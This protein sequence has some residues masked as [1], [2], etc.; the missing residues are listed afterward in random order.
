[1]ITFY[2]NG[3]IHTMDNSKPLA[4]ALIVENG[5]F[6]YVGREEEDRKSVV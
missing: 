2:M 1:M 3:N 5:A 6:S 4:N